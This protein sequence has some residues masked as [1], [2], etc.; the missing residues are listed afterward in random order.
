MRERRT[1]GVEHRAVERHV[2]FRASAG[3]NDGDRVTLRVVVVVE[4]VEADSLV[5]SRDA[6]RIVARDRYCILTG[7]RDR[8]L[9]NSAFASRAGNCVLDID[10]RRIVRAES[11]KVSPVGD[12]RQGPVGINLQGTTDIREHLE[13]GHRNAVAVDIR[14]VRKHPFTRGHFKRPRLGQG[15]AVRHRE[16]RIWHRTDVK[17]ERVL[18]AF[19]IA[20]A[21]GEEETRNSGT[22][23]VG[24][25][26]EDQVVQVSGRDQL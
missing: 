18:I 25:G 20:I 17:A 12:E 2:T 13:R 22:V 10:N 8:H 19:Q 24:L 21:D 15:V 14:V 23:E 26:D 11:G 9:A 7:H 1:R 4:E 16:R 6:E 5:R 3:G